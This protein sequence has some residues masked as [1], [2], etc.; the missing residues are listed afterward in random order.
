MENLKNK[1]EAMINEQK[2]AEALKI[3]NSELERKDT[4]NSDFVALLY[5]SKGFILH[6]FEKYEE[7][8]ECFDEA[9]IL[10]P[11]KT[12][13]YFNRGFSKSAAENYYG[14]IN[15]FTQALKETPKANYIY[16]NRGFAYEMTYEYKKAQ[17]DYRKAIELGLD[18][19]D[20]FYRLGGI[21]NS[22][23]Q[24]SDAIESYTKAIN[25]EENPILIAILYAKRGDIKTRLEDLESALEDY[26]LGLEYDSNNEDCQNGLE[27]TSYQIEDKNQELEQL[28]NLSEKIDKGI[29]LAESYYQRGDLYY[30][31]FEKYNEAIADYTKLVE[32]ITTEELS[33]IK[34]YALATIPRCYHYMNDFVEEI[35]AYKKALEYYP[36]D[37]EFY[38]KIANVQKNYLEDLESA[39]ETYKIGI[40]NCTE[41]KEAY[42]ELAQLYLKQKKYE[43][44]ENAALKDI[45]IKNNLRC[46]N[47][48]NILGDIRFEQEQYNEA[49]D[50]YRKALGQGETY[51]IE[52]IS[53][54]FDYTDFF[55]KEK[56]A[57]TLIKLKEYNKA[58]E[59]LNEL[60]E[61]GEYNDKLIAQRAEIYLILG[62]KQEALQDITRA[63]NI[64]NENQ[65]L[66]E[67]RETIIL[68]LNKE[69]NT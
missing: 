1:I 27:Y 23:K 46:H 49:I 34:K 26:K 52:A 64:D 17:E 41:L 69:E 5:Y 9:I 68:S 15:D 55:V 21:Q 29:E 42:Y 44:A 58:I 3:C 62:K 57:K 66:M 22:E 8:I 59:L 61:I 47:T 48:Y 4:Y 50:F 60:I 19:S 54:I 6:N 40:E 28:Q 53:S 65:K 7:A 39:I 18:N 63:L 10:A 67:L 25:K 33:H 43:D 12:S 32:L 31:N 16:Y 56:I 36:D 51:D 24:Y 11:N 37:I 35:N 38:E 14:A 2:Y 13:I 20:I 30:R 45:E